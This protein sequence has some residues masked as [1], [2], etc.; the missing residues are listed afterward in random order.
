M[1]K[2][3]AERLCEA[4]GAARRSVV[5]S[6]LLRQRWLRRVVAVMAACIALWFAVP[7]PDPPFPE[8]YSPVVLDKGGALLSAFLAC[9]DQWRF[10]AD[11]LEVSPKLVDAVLTFEDRRFPRHFGIDPAALVRAALSNLRAHKVSSGASTLTMQVARLMNPK[12]RTLAHKLLEMAQAIK[13]EARYSKD[14][15]L[16]MYMAHAPYG[17]NI[18]GVHAASFLFFGRPPSRL[19]WAEAATL[20]VLPKAPSQISL[21]SRR[22]ELLRRRNRLLQALHGRGLLSDSEMTYAMA[23]PLPATMMPMPSTAP[24]L[25]RRV[26]A[27]SPVVRTTIDHSLQ[28]GV[29]TLVSRHAQMLARQGIHNLSVLVAET[30]TGLVRAYVGSA[31]FWDAAHAGQVDGIVARRSTGSLLKPFLYARCIDDGAVH[32]ATLVKDVPVHYGSY[33]PVNADRGFSGMVTAREALV[34]SLNVPPTILL[35]SHGVA[36][37]HDFLRTAG[38]STLFRRPEDYGLTLVLGGAE[39]TLWDMV[40]LFRG[41]GRL[42]RFDGLS[43]LEGSPPSQ[44]LQLLSPAA[45]WMTLDMLTEVRR[46]DDDGVDW[47][48]FPTRRPVAWKT[49]TSFGKRDGWAL[50]VTPRW[51]VGV[52]AGNFSGEGSERL[53]GARSAA[54]LLFGLLDLLPPGGRLWFEKPIGAFRPALLCA[55]TGYRVGPDCTDTIEAEVPLHARPLPPCPFHRRFHL[56]LH[57]D[58]E[59]CSRCW[60]HADSVRQEIRLLFPADVRQFLRAAGHTL[61]RH[62]PHHPSCPTLSGDSPVDII[63]P[64]RQARLFVPRDI[65]GSYQKVTLRAAHSAADA[66]LYWYLDQSFLGATVGEHAMPAD[67]AGGRHSLQVIDHTGHARQVSFTVVRR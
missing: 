50:G 66:T 62:P 65:D 14:G 28:D 63:Y 46:P 27:E 19:T 42:G 26:A 7:L 20:A 56:D 54:P 11:A 58:L 47:T 60:S 3:A 25:C 4:F 53:G 37:F 35:R 41:L 51:V 23:E 5:S 33:A 13:L 67:L 52:W 17:R 57:R 48:A 22:D 36:P 49:G 15:I 61:Q 39:G 34:R 18:V 59:V 21:F 2:A 64:S 10:R 44:G 38:M 16:A 24:H 31:S 1:M 43:V 29:E 30:E 40:A 12:R 45:A 8:I 32:P 9:D 6:G 55:A